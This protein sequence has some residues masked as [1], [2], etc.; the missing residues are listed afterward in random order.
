MASREGL[1]DSPP[2]GSKAVMRMF[3]IFERGELLEEATFD[4]FPITAALFSEAS[5]VTFLAQFSLRFGDFTRLSD[6]RFIGMVFICIPG[7]RGGDS[8]LDDLRDGDRLLVICLVRRDCEFVANFEGGGWLDGFTITFDFATIT[9][10]CSL[11][12]CFE[13]AGCPEPFIGAKRRWR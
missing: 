6:K 13:E 11:T 2:K 4:L 8:L 5:L 9:S 3:F 12:S 10:L 1:I 7:E